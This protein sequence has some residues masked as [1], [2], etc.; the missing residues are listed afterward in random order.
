MHLWR[1]RKEEPGSPRRGVARAATESAPREELAREAM[2]VLHEGSAADRIGV[3]L[4]PQAHSER[5]DEWPA[6]FRGVIWDKEADATPA[7]W[8]RMSPE[9]PLPQELLD[10]RTVEQALDGSG[11]EAVLGPLI[12]MHHALWVPVA[13][14]GRLRG[15]LLAATRVKQVVLPKILFESVAAE[16][17]L[18]ME[19]EE[20]QRAARE[21]RAD[22]KLTR[23]MMEGLER[24]APED[25]ILAAIVEDCTKTRVHDSGPGALFAGI[26]VK[27]EEPVQD[28]VKMIFPWRQGDS[29]WTETLE[30]EPISGICR[31][32]LE[33]RRV[34]GSESHSS[35]SR[36]EPAR[37]VA[38][39]LEAGGEIL[40][41][42]V[43]GLRNGS[44]SLATL[45]RLGLRASLATAAL[46]REQRNAED[47]RKSAWQRALLESSSVAALFLTAEGRIAALSR[48]AT[49][50][51]GVRP[52]NGA[53]GQSAKNPEM[54]PL[55]PGMEEFKA[56]FSPSEQERAA[57]W[58]RR[59]LLQI[60]AGRSPGEDGCE[61]VLRN[62]QRIRVGMVLPADGGRAAVTFEA[63]KSESEFISERS[64]A[65][66]LNVLEWLE[67]GVVLFDANDGIRAMNSRFAQIAGLTPAEAT[68]IKSLED[69]I[70]RLK[71][72]AAEPDS[73]A[74]HWRELAR[75]SDGGVR[76]EL[77]L[78]RPIPRVLERASRPVL[79][80][81]GRR[82]GRVEIYRD[83]TARRVF[84]SK[85]LQ[86]EKLASLGQMVTGVAHELSNP[87]TSILGYA[88][89]LVTRGQ[90]AERQEEAG[91][92]YEEAERANTILR[93]LLLS[94]RETRPERRTVSLNQMVLRTLEL[95]RFG[96][97]ARQIL[98]EMDLDPDLPLVQGDPGQL[99]QVLLNLVANARQAIEESQKG[100][101]IRVR[102]KRTTEGRVLLEVSDDGPGIPEAIQA[103]IFD[104]FF[105][106]KPE[107]LGTGLGLSIVLGIVGEHGGQ[108]HVTSPPGGGAT[109]RIELTAAANRLTE[110]RSVPQENPKRGLEKSHREVTHRIEIPPSAARAGDAATRVLVVEDEPIVARLIADVLEDEGMRVDVLL[111]GREALERAARERYDL[112]ICDMKMPGLNGQHFY[113]AL[114]RS[115][116][117][118][119]DRFLFVTGDVVAAHTQQF[120]ER[121]NLPHVA[122][123]FRMEE[124]TEKVRQVLQGEVAGGAYAAAQRGTVP[125]KNV[126]T[127]G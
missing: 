126:A 27:S 36:T 69:L 101:R 98:V 5:D 63:V 127:S 46:A 6:I 7:E 102:S 117:P 78:A 100:G 24:G 121:H 11:K 51:L 84:Q 89:R 112:V 31:Q 67:E 35:S 95:Q 16:L 3:W 22:I 125:K 59:I 45:E 106:T 90:T 92:I 44:A 23:Q 115:G 97:G 83:E 34:A 114:E 96:T 68:K 32:A 80:A 14:D 12:E 33:N 122:K 2:R 18:G 72:G 8:M 42:L 26:G 109:F 108:V 77:R 65:E 58:V 13:R 118:L 41:V 60:H 123:P 94:A 93:Q 10:G 91:R 29:A 40:G 38:L 20:Q 62:G 55:A 19:V 49:D 103:R 57:A 79:D 4:E 54:C 99:Q 76:D 113:N 82:L 25:S 70:N 119:R 39:P 107:G 75:A 50:L 17:L 74:L 87:L 28:A 21:L 64:G 81:A 111:D 71:S 53:A 73:F 61:F 15:V 48:G 124:L 56:L 9:F 120:L 116:N 104:P 110:D 88:Q 85:L 105:T 86:T 47:R 37:I 66:L 43:A 52:E 1:K 30:S